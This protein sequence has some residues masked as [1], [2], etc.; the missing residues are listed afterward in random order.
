MNTNLSKDITQDIA[1][2]NESP[3]VFVYFELGKSE[4]EQY[5]ISIAQLNTNSDLSGFSINKQYK[6]YNNISTYLKY[7]INGKDNKLYASFCIEQDVDKLSRDIIDDFLF[8][9]LVENEKTKEVTEYNVHL[10][11][12]FTLNGIIQE[13]NNKI[14]NEYSSHMVLR[15]NP[16]LSGNIKLVVSPNYDLFLDTFPVTPTLA[17]KE[18]RKR[19]VSA[20]SSYSKDIYSYFSKIPTSDIFN[21]NDYDTYDISL[22]KRSYE[23]QYSTTYNYGAR[24]LNEELYSE[25]Y[26]LLAPLW[27]NNTLP[28]YFV[29]FR[30]EGS[31]NKETYDDSLPTDQL[32]KKFLS[33]GKIVKSWSLKDSTP[34]GKYLNTHLKELKSIGSNVYISLDSEVNNSWGGVPIKYGVMTELSETT[35]EFDNIANAQQKNFSPKKA[36]TE[37]NNYVTEGFNRNGLVCPNLLNLQFHFNDDEIE[38]FDMCRYF[39]LYLS[40]NDLFNYNYY[41]GE[42]INLDTDD[43]ILNS[44]NQILTEEKDMIFGLVENEVIKRVTDVNDIKVGH[45][46]NYVT[47]NKVS[48]LTKKLDEGKFVSMTFQDGI[49]SGEHF[50]VSFYKDGI[51]S[52]FEAVSVGVNVLQKGEVYNYT[53]AVI[54]DENLY[55]VAFCVSDDDTNIDSCIALNKAFNVLFN[56][57][58]G[59]SSY[60][61]DNK[62]SILVN[63]IAIN[64]VKLEFITSELLLDMDNFLDVSYN[65]TVHDFDDF[66]CIENIKFFGYYSLKRSDARIIQYNEIPSYQI[67]GPRLKYSIN[68]MH[69]SDKMH[70]YSLEDNLTIDITE[71]NVYKF[72]DNFYKFENIKKYLP[73]NNEIDGLIIEHPLSNKKCVLSKTLIDIIMGGITIYTLC[74]VSFNIFS[75]TQVKDF[76][77]TVY[78]DN[79]KFKSAYSYNREDDSKLSNLILKNGESVILKLQDCYKIFN[80]KGFIK[81]SFSANR[82]NFSVEDVPFEFNTFKGSIEVVAESDVVLCRTNLNELDTE[83]YYYDGYDLSKDYSEESFNTYL[84]SNSR[85]KYGLTT[86]YVCKWVLQGNDCRSNRLLLKTNNYPFKGDGIYSNFIPLEINDVKLFNDEIAYP[87]FT[88]LDE[89]KRG[90]NSYVK[91]DINDRFTYQKNDTS[92]VRSLKELYLD[93]DSNIDVFSKIMYSN[94]ADNY[95]TKKTSIL[96]YNKFYNSLGTVFRGLKLSFRLSDKVVDN[97]MID[98]YSFSMVLSNSNNKTSNKPFDVFINN[99]FKNVLIVWYANSKELNYTARHNSFVEYKNFID[100]T[101]SNMV[102]NA[103]KIPK[104]GDNSTPFGAYNYT[105]ADFVLNTNMNVYE[106]I[107]MDEYGIPSVFNVQTTSQYDYLYQ[108]SKNTLS[109]VEKFTYIYNGRYSGKYMER[110]SFFEVFN[111]FNNT[112]TDIISGVNTYG[113]YITNNTYIFKT[114]NNVH[115]DKIG[116]LDMFKNLIKNSNNFTVYIINDDYVFNSNTSKVADVLSISIEAPKL[117]NKS[118]YSHAGWYTPLFKNILEFHSNSNTLFSNIFNIDI[119]FSNTKVKRVCNIEQLWYYKVKDVIVDADIKENKS[120]DYR[121]DYNPMLSQWDKAYYVN[122]NIKDGNNSV[123]TF[124]DGYVNPIEQSSMFGSKLVKLPNEISI[125][126][127]TN[128]TAKVSYY[129]SSFTEESTDTEKLKLEFNIT[130]SLRNIFFNSKFIDNWSGLE[131]QDIDTVIGNYI[132]ST[133]IPLYDKHMN[134]IQVNIYIADFDGNHILHKR[135]GYCA[136]TNKVYNTELT[137]EFDNYIYNII[138]PKNTLVSYYVEIIIK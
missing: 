40:A 18:V 60:I 16:K 44:V 6:D 56:D 72:K 109:G 49:H 36:F 130:E 26:S 22:P 138:V 55:T 96:K 127:W 121:T 59:V 137:K 126:E 100:N 101:N 85:L 17:K 34:L 134:K 37:L 62:I 39:G 124:V 15:T 28:E 105:N 128:N 73:N 112:N 51:K 99:I 115:K 81:P 120:I 30:V 69:L 32:L 71:K 21:L 4:T 24:M 123:K 122:Y 38:E 61:L 103:Y 58:V 119:S 67:Y 107:R 84:E 31:Y 135:P 11:R 108:D 12:N 53:H 29:I 9:F 68:F 97:K 63:D 3:R 43:S 80:G 54:G 2:Y 78:F 41:N 66:G 77:F 89:S 27:I 8:T 116:T 14:V 88:C 133:I 20:V 13:S 132:N 35:Y 90:A 93:K 110:G 111:N 82:I 1:I 52:V 75:I 94:F 79:E 95:D 48:T 70:A 102:L 74:D 106:I 65:K 114:A 91:Y 86:P 64:N 104:D 98:G 129:D 113:D 92:V 87:T 25:K 7:E 50:R 45:A 125:N 117:Y 33:E 118:I 57:I 83:S 46:D 5:K 42:I 136:K 23:Y 19:E 76:D 47:S 10:Y 131:N